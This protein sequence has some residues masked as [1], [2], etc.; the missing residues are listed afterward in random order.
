MLSQGFTKAEIDDLAKGIT[1]DGFTWHHHQDDGIMQLIPFGE[2]NLWNHNG[3]RTS[4]FW[5]EGG[6]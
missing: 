1:P 6:R 2:H 3:G 4:G 5:A